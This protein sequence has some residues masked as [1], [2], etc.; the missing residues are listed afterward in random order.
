[1]K[2]LKI[3]ENFNELN[4]GDYLILD[5]DSVNKEYNA[6][7]AR[8]AQY[9]IIVIEN[10]ENEHN[11]VFGIMMTKISFKK[12]YLCLNDQIQPY[13]NQLIHNLNYQI[14]K[15]YIIFKSNKLEEC[16]EH[17]NTLLQTNKYNL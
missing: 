1:M 12:I 5:L 14:L 4:V 10:I 8:D 16:V 3:Y 6:G 9:Y 7:R 13:K 17:L 11:Q 2:H 15:R